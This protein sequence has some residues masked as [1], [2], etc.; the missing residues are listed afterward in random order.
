MQGCF[1]LSFQLGTAKLFMTMI[2]PSHPIPGLRIWYQQC[3]RLPAATCWYW[4][5]YDICVSKLIML[6]NPWLANVCTL[7]NSCETQSSKT[8][9][10]LKSHFTTAWLQA[11]AGGSIWLNT[12]RRNRLSVNCSLLFVFC[13]FYFTLVTFMVYFHIILDLELYY[14]F[15]RLS[16]DKQ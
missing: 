1:W 10:S 12:G 14:P 13:F 5:Y 6:R 16:N 7:V 9:W 11:R 15:D 4:W 2:F 3:C 8:S